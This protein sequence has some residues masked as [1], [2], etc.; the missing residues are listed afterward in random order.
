MDERHNV[1]ATPS[2][3]D[4]SDVL[5]YSDGL[6]CVLDTNFVEANVTGGYNHSEGVCTTSQDPYT[7]GRKLTRPQWGP[8]PSRRHDPDTVCREDPS[9]LQ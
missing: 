9:R 5:T 1:V 4:R 7:G 2:G 6:T 3:V 8:F